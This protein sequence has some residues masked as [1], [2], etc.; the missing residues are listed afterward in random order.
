MLFI[1]PV[2]DTNISLSRRKLLENAVTRH[3]SV[4]VN[5]VIDPS[6]L[7]K[8]LQGRGLDPGKPKDL[9][10]FA[11]EERCGAYM[12]ISS[13]EINRVYAVVWTKV[14]AHVRLVLKNIESNQMLWW[15]KHTAQRGDGG[16]PITLIS[17]GLSSFSAGRLASDNDALP[18][19]L[20]DTVRRLMLTLP[21]MRHP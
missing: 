16:L 20:E 8:K 1:L 7:L 5:R 17:A 14:S 3:L 4:R 19:V 12:T 21:D 18:S 13:A 2:R 11:L 15:G 6:Y 10:R 9:R